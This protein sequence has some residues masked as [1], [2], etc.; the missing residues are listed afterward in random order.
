MTD[1][2]KLD[3]K[4]LQS[5]IDND[6]HQF[7]A[8]IAAL[9]VSNPDRRSLYDV[10]NATDVFVLGSMANDSDT[11]GKSVVSNTVTAAKAIDDVFNRHSTAFADLDRNLRSVITTM[12]KTQGDSLADVDGQKFLSAIVDYNGDMYGTQGGSAAGSSGGAS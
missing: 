9:R 10:G 12:L 11:A 1:L 6:V 7:Q 4:V 2:T 8:D 5:F 3:A